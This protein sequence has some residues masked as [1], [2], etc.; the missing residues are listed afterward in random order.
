MNGL[1]GKAQNP[2]EVDMPPPPRWELAAVPVPYAEA[3]ARMEEL[4]A[5][6]AAGKAAETI[7]LLEHPPV[8]TAGTSADPAELVDPGGLPVVQS[9]RGG[10][11]TWH[12]PGQRVVYA[13]LDL[14]R[15]GRNL[16][17]LVAALEG[18]AIAALADLGIAAHRS[19]RGTG[20]WVA[21]ADAAGE[22]K[23]AAIGLRVRRWVSFHGIAIN[24]APD[25]SGFA[26]F[27]PCGIADARPARLI[28][29]DPAID[30]A[31]LDAALERNLAGLLSAIGGGGL[32][33]GSKAG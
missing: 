22:A 17:G 18:W 13:M 15:R 10:R 32:E 30:M 16:H 25:L 1:A 9:G 6:I 3:V 27:V 19:A 33:A 28:D 4:V 20:V 2:L 29:L 5:D 24:V 14:G 21:S 26:G 11:F 23:V 7:W 12:G 31:A 8:I